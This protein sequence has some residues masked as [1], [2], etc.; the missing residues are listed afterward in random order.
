MDGLKAAE[1]SAAWEKDGSGL[2]STWVS[3][4]TRSGKSVRSEIAT[5]TAVAIIAPVTTEIRL[6][7]M[8]R[9]QLY[10]S[11]SS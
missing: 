11:V 1:E 4:T 5:I 2:N 3:L 6:T 9:Y 10:S 8:M 7:D